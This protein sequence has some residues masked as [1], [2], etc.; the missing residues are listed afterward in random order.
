MPYLLFLSLRPYF[1]VNYD[2]FSILPTVK[3]SLEKQELKKCVSVHINKKH[4]LQPSCHFLGH[5]VSIIQMGRAGSSIAMA[6]LA[7]QI[8]PEKENEEGKWIHPLK[9]SLF[10]SLF[11]H[12]LST[13]SFPLS[14]II[15]SIIL[16]LHS[17]CNWRGGEE[18][19]NTDVIL[20]HFTLSLFL[21]Y[22]HT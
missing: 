18:E 11:P 15:N 20:D 16:P 19:T 14:D 5:I 17:G 21:T 12:S 7:K 8:E 1:I 10:L 9:N 13:H 6:M 3:I 4:I 22:T 2:L